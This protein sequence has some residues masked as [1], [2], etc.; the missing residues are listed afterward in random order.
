MVALW[1]QSPYSSHCRT[2]TLSAPTLSTLTSLTAI[3]NDWS[4]EC[5]CYFCDM[6]SLKTLYVHFMFIYMYVHHLLIPH[7]HV[8]E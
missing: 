7:L 8:G 3:F 4:L 6:C 1:S 2:V 5:T